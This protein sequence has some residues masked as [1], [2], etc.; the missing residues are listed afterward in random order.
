MSVRDC[1][2]A[3]ERLP[4]YLPGE[5]LMRQSGGPDKVGAIAA[6]GRGCVRAGDRMGH[7]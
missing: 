4:V 3:A 7:G 6:G 2:P 1:I 5:A